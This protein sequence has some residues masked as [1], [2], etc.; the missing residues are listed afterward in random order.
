MTVVPAVMPV[1]TPV[2]DTEATAG[3]LETQVTDLSVASVGETVGT[4]LRVEPTAT[5]E[6]IGETVTPVTGTVLRPL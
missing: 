4:M 1:A 3:T 6:F 5:V 2:L